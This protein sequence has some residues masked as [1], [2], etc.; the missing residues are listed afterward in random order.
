M[1][2]RE[3]ET[4]TAHMVLTKP[5]SRGVLIAGKA[6]GVFLLHT[7]LLV[8]GTAC[9]FFLVQWRVNHG[10][11]PAEELERLRAEVLV[12]RRFIPPPMPDF[13]ALA[14]REYQARQKA[15]EVPADATEVSVKSDLLHQVKAAYTEIPYGQQRGWVYRNV[16]V[17]PGVEPVQVRFR[18]YVG[19]ARSGNQRETA[20]VWAFRVP[21]EGEPTFRSLAIRMTG[22]VFEQM[23]LPREAVADDGTVELRYAN[24]DPARES[25]VLQLGDRPT[26]MIRAAGFAQNSARAVALLVLQLAFLSILG[27][28]VSALFSTPVAVFAGLSYLVIG[29]AADMA[30]AD[31]DPEM[32]FLSPP[33]VQRRISHGLAGSLR[34]VVAS[35]QD[36][37]VAKNLSRGHLISFARVG[38]V[39]GTVVVVQGGILLGLGTLVF[40]RRELGKV[41]RR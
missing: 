34:L 25:Q 30:M 17:G 9:I 33:S 5:V 28:V 29:M 7:L 37:S 20:G 31:V 21:G 13:V 11:F 18:L 32:K 8:V 1:L 40:R 41:V 16:P 26:L 19:A 38:W 22:G 6:A 27:T 12:G 14:R 4:Y 15:G 35:P 24:A 10:G 23:T 36:F 3:I 39:F 2:A